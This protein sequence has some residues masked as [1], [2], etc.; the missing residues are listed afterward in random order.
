[1]ASNIIIGILSLKLYREI[2]QKFSFYLSNRLSC[3]FTGIADPIGRAVS[4]A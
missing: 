2:S 1:M 3:P 4:K